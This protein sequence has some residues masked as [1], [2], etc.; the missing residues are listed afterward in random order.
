ML[1]KGSGKLS[2]MRLVLDI[3]KKGRELQFS[4]E[5][6][7]V[8]RDNQFLQKADAL[9][10][11]ID[12][13]KAISGAD[14]NDLAVRLGPFTVDLFATGLNAI[15]NRFYTQSAEEGSRGVD[16]FTQRWEGEHV[17]AAPLVSLA[18]RTIRNAADVI[19]GGVLIV[20]LWK[21]A[22]YW[23]LAFDGGRQLNPV[24]AGMQIVRMRALAWEITARDSPLGRELQ[25]LV[26]CLKVGKVERLL[27]SPRGEGR[28]FR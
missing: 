1:S 9:S 28:C 18:L 19:L 27:E 6:V 11:G 20:S 10:K 3:L 4:F 23:T 16:A 17:Y 13:D 24:F 25:F 14:F 21:S 2:V 22:K 15:C 5:P 8:S 12:S 26:L 7:W